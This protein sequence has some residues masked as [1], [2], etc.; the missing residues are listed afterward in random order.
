LKNENRGWSIAAHISMILYTVMVII[1]FI[2]LISASLT[3]QKAIYANGFSFWPSKFSMA[4]YEYILSADSGILRAYGVSFF[5]TV[6]GTALS[7]IITALLAYPLSRSIMPHRTFWMFI[8]VFTMLFHGGMV[9]SYLVWTQLIHIKNT[10]WA[11][12]IPGFLMNGFNVL[13]MR[14]FFR[15]TIPG[16]LIESAEMDGASEFRILRSIVVP[17]STPVLATIG[18]M[19]SIL[20]WND[21]QNGKIYITKPE[22]FSVQNLLNRI[23]EDI[24]FLKTNMPAGSAAAMANLPSESA[25][26]AIAVIGVLPILLAYPF[27]QKYLVKGIMIGAIKG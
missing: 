1:P 26:M 25:R 27:F 23:M 21:W 10:I 15:N 3:D 7:L 14:T 9:P 4:A 13:L 5:V 11:L 2:L 20:Y 6:V 12:I 24:Q 8:I 19:Q 18:L 17:L 16:E 22:L